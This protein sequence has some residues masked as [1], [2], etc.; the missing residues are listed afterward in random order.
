MRA[1]V[2]ALDAL[3]GDA[4]TGGKRPR[5]ACSSAVMVQ[6]P[7]WLAP[8]PRA[9]SLLQQ[10]A[11]HPCRLFVRREALGEQVGRGLVARLVGAR[12]EFARGARDRLVAFNQ[13]AH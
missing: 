11:Q 1:E 12:K 8:V 4:A 2:R 5:M 9:A 10:R 7:A 13:D 3:S 6:G